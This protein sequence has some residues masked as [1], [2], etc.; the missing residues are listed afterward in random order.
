MLHVAAFLAHNML[1]SDQEV[2]VNF[3]EDIVVNLFNLSPDIAFQ[4]LNGFW[5]RISIHFAF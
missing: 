2:V 4:L 5:D 1:Q 3:G